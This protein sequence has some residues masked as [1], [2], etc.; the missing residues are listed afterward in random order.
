MK[1][2]KHKIWVRYHELPSDINYP[3]SVTCG[4]TLTY[5]HNYT[6][7]YKDYNIRINDIIIK[8]IRGV[9]NT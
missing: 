3:Y 9:Y 8:K 6:H 7:T 1:H 2:Y 4:A 5:E